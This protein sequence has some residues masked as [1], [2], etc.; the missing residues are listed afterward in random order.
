MPIATDIA[1][2]LVNGIFAGAVY[3]LMSVGLSVIWGVMN[4]LNCAQGAFYMLSAFLSLFA[5]ETLGLD[6]FLSLFF[7]LPLLFVIG[8]LIE[9]FLIKP[10]RNSE[11]AIVIL[12]FGLAIFLEEA[13]RL[14]AGSVYRGFPMQF[15]QVFQVFGVTVEAQRLFVFVFSVAVTTTFY[16]FLRSIKL[17]K[18]IRAVSQ[19]RNLAM[20]VGVDIDRVF[21]LTFGICTVLSGL[22]GYAVSPLININPRMG[23]ATIMVMF[24]TVVLGGLGS[25]EG[26]IIAG[27]IYG[28][29]EAFAGYYIGAQYKELTIL[30]VLLFML[31]FRPQGLFGKRA[32]RV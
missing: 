22:A 32:E 3:S 24:A 13:V 18:V 4:V 17:G 23:W 5:V 26:T 19:N 30:V 20:L 6:P 28:T 7:T 14:T 11:S 9:R 10:I 16:L 2:L 25:V 1:Q 21:L 12:T 29:V 27:F 31:V 8:V 15:T